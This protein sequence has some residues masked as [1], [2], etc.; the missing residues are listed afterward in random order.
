MSLNWVMLDERK[1]PVPL[2]NERT[3]STIPNA[4]M[5]LH[6]PNSSDSNTNPTQTL[7]A[8]GDIWL[9]SDR[10]VFVAAPESQSTSLGLFALVS[11]AI[12]S[13]PANETSST[14]LETLSLPWLSVLST[15]FVQP[16]FGAN[17]LAMDVRPAEG[18]G[19]ALGTKAEVRLTNRGMFEFIG[20]VEGIRNKAIERAR[21]ARLGEPLPIYNQPQPGAAPPVEDLPPGYTA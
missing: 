15:S 4:Q 1:K 19:L 12:S 16:Y 7:T 18:G 10:F 20:M 9:T 11:Q 21:E 5:T 8:S 14:K 3:I 17:Y 6:L 2:P 13:A